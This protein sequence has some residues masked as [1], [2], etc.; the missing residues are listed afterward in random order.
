MLDT[1]TYGIKCCLNMMIGSP[2]NSLG[3]RAEIYDS[4]FKY[5]FYL[6]HAKITPLCRGGCE[7]NMYKKLSRKKIQNVEKKN[8]LRKKN[9]SLLK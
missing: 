3:F 8:V 1:Q 2:M 4:V 7:L 6:I 9:S 5:D